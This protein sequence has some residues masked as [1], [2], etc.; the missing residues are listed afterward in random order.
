MM[1]CGC[2]LG[3]VMLVGDVHLNEGTAVGPA[4]QARRW[5][6]KTD[7]DGKPDPSIVIIFRQPLALVI[8][9]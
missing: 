2:H 6:G 5:A 1:G 4:P 8:I 7:G 3:R 9:S